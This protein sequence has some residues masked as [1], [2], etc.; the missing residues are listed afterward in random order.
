MSKDNLGDYIDIWLQLKKEAKETKD[1]SM[2]KWFLLETKKMFSKLYAESK[3]EPMQ[4]F[5]AKV[6]KTTTCEIKEIDIKYKES[7]LPF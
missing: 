7:E 2:Y 1:W 5:L 3:W 4:E 6:I